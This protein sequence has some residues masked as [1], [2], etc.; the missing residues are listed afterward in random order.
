MK[1]INVDISKDLDTLI[2]QL[3]ITYQIEKRLNK[4]NSIEL[5]KERLNSEDR[6]VILKTP[7]TKYIQFSKRLVVAFQLEEIITIE[8]VLTLRHGQVLRMYGVGRAACNEWVELVTS[9]EIL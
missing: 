9:L 4:K 8:D 1:T 6:E 5:L 2:Q 3:R 7:Y